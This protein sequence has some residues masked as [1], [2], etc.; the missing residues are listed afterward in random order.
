MMTK[1]YSREFESSPQFTWTNAGVISAGATLAVSWGSYN[2][3]SK[4]YLPFNFTRI[5]NNSAVEIIVYPNQ[6][7]NNPIYVPNGTIL[8]VDK[9]NL[10]AVSS[11]SIKN[12]GAGNVTASQIV[13]SN[14][15]EG[16]TSDGIL[17]RLHKRL[18][19]GN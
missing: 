14:S 7:T 17:S 8:S 19:G 9:V 6:D 10:P 1:S 16:V 18:L 5:I 2:T 3:S 4:K 13:V 15:R 11:F 12:N